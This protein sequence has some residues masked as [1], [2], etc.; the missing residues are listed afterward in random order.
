MKRKQFSTR[1]KSRSNQPRITSPTQSR[2]GLSKQSNAN[3][4]SGIRGRGS[5]FL[6]RITFTRRRSMPAYRRTFARTDPRLTRDGKVVSDINGQ[7]Y[8]ARYFVRTTYRGTHGRDRHQPRILCHGCAV[9]DCIS[10]AEADYGRSRSI[11]KLGPV[12]NAFA[13]AFRLEAW[14]I[15]TSPHGSPN[16]AFVLLTTS[17]N[18][19][20]SFFR[21]ALNV[22]L[23]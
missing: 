11:V 6:I 21:R 1:T 13:A 16:S 22:L 3:A 23:S 8:D 19:E 4:L 9:R 18:F 10:A 15:A 12:I 20:A 17:F 2:V 7:S 5:A 14:S